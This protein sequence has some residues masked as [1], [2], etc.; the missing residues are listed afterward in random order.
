MLLDKLIEELKKA[1]SVAIIS[2]ISPDG[3]TLGCGLALYQALK[4][5]GIMPYIF[6][7]DEISEKLKFIPNSS[8]INIKSANYYDLAISVDCGDLGRL[9]LSSE[10]FFKAKVTVNI[11]HH[12]TN[13]RFA[14][15]NIVKITSATAEIVCEL[16][17][18]MEILDNISARAL[19]CGLI[20]D[21]G[22][23]T[24]SS[25]NPNTFLVAG[26][27]M[28]YDISAHEICEHFMK[29]TP[30]NKFKL[31]AR[32]L[33]NAQ[34]YDDNRIGIVVFRNSDFSMTD[35]TGSDT[36]GMINDIRNVDSVRV[37][38]SIAEAGKDIFKI[39]FRTGEDVDSSRIA[40]VFGG[41]GHKNASGCKLLGCF[42]EVLEKVLKAVRDEI[43]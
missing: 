34:F 30:I 15:I 14:D 16:L 31:K 1:K 27:L 32:V 5:Y 26:K 20:T 3:D 38:V 42:E 21:S 25:V 41:G 18:R 35:T 9:G 8:A 40:M 23:F 7:D 39:S 17:N 2:H 37:A 10:E 24:Y 6:C 36:E 28:A 12:K 22:G 11:D 33:N 19:Y 43:C 4:L 29:S 13:T